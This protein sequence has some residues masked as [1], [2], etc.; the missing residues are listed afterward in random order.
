MRF[1][2]IRAEPPVD[3]T[4][5]LGGE[6]NSWTSERLGG[7]GDYPNGGMWLF[8]ESSSGAN[9][10]VVKRTGADH[11][12]GSRVWSG[13]AEPDDPHWWGRE[14]AFYE[15][16][17]AIS[18]WPEGVRAAECYVVDDHDRCRDLW[19]EH[20][21]IPVTSLD[22]YRRTVAGLAAWQVANADADQPWLSRDWI[23]NHVAR[24]DL[25]NR[26]TIDHPGWDR[27]MERGLDPSLR[28]TVA[29][30]VTDP[31]I[32]RQI[33]DHF[34]QLP[35]HFDLHRENIGRAGS[36]LV[37]IDWALVGHG[38]IGHD[39]GLLAIEAS[40]RLG[41]S[42]RELW[43][44]LTDAYLDGLRTVGWS[45]DSEVVRQSIAVSAV[46]RLGF[47]VDFVLDTIDQLPEDQ[48]GPTADALLFLTEIARD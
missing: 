28:D 34:P 41:L 25:D 5:R 46:I 3:V 36:D 43:P 15:S 20:V 14:A 1:G 40:P 9:Q 35:T 18:G 30:R 11:L 37:I 48:V 42:V 24:H 39:A 12:G 32:A 44:A 7:D 6:Q 23:P 31:A 4:K 10:A 16:T 33:L 38:P 17:L 29:D 2:P 19:L 45:G 26:R 27:A 22:D 8:T 47:F 13:R 21:T